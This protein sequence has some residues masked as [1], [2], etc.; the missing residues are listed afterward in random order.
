MTNEVVV[1]G[2]YCEVLEVKLA[3]NYQYSDSYTTILFCIK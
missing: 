3:S 1:V 2:N